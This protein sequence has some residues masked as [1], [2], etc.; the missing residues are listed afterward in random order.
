MKVL[1]II[2]RW[3]IPVAIQKKIAV[4][5]LRMRMSILI[6]IICGFFIFPGFA[7]SANR[8]GISLASYN[9]E[10]LFDLTRDSTEY[11]GYIPGGRHG[12]DREMLNAKLDH[13]ARVINDLDADIL[14]L[15]EVESRA[16]LDLLNQRLEKPYPHTTIADKKPTT[17]KCALMSRF[18]VVETNE[19]AVPGKAARNILKAEI[20]IADH[21][22]IVFVNHWK[23]KTGP[24]SRRLPY[25]RALADAIEKLDADADFVI[26]G[27]LNSNYNEFKTFKNAEALNDTSGITGINHILNTVRQDRLVSERMLS[28]QPQNG[29]Y[30]YNLWL[31]LKTGRRWSVKFFRQKN[32]PDHIIVSPGLYDNEGISYIDNSFDKFDPGYLFRGDRIRRWQR[33]DKGRGKHLGKGFSDH[34]PIFAWFAPRPFSYRPDAPYPEKTVPIAALYE[35]KTGRVNYHLRRCLVIYKHQKYTI[36]K[37]RDGRATLVY[38][39]GEQ[40]KRGHMYNLTAKYLKRYYGMLEITRLASVRSI[41]EALD[42][43]EFFIEPADRSLADSEFVNEVVRRIEG[44]YR[45]GWLHYGGHRKIRLFAKDKSLLPENGSSIILRNVRI[46]FHHHPELVLERSGQIVVNRAVEDE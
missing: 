2:N 13:M 32:S 11:P 40:L 3:V 17:V 15:Q 28:R 39:S 31:E 7:F 27:D 41:K 21:S 18:P 9:V 42:V 5:L 23:S 12:W 6:G 37:Q 22:F 20:E 38:E 24:E 10:N 25:A 33:T 19:I 16:A 44:V 45:D 46:G 35:S 4:K 26:V 29:I 1:K 43:T 36:I 30:L 34:L 14:A 8:T